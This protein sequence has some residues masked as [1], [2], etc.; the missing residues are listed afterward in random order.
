MR[1]G[2]GRGRGGQSSSLQRGGKTALASRGA[3]SADAAAADDVRKSYLRTAVGE[4]LKS[5]LAEYRLQALQ[6]GEDSTVARQDA[7][8]WSMVEDSIYKAFYD[9]FA[10][11]F[12]GP[13]VQRNMQMNGTASYRNVD[14]KWMFAVQNPVFDG[15]DMDI[16]T[17]VVLVAAGDGK[18]VPAP[19]TAGTDG[20]GAPAPPPDDDDDD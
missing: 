7:K 6:H 12:A 20:S 8:L 3:S 5:T 16:K 4:A 11:V 18:R 15:C 10:E 9:S 17:P 1:R 14:D 19:S 13:L 2:R